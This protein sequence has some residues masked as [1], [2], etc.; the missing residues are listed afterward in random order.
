MEDIKKLPIEMLLDKLAYYTAKHVKLFREGRRD[1]EYTEC[2]KMI[3]L[4]TKEIEAKKKSK[5]S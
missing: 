4:L 1:D 2:K 3:N 5:S